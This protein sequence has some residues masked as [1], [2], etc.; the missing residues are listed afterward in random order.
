M[1]RQKMK[2]I[3]MAALLLCGTG[4]GTGTVRADPAVV[5]TDSLNVRSKPDAESTIIAGLSRGDKVTALDERFGWVK[6]Q[7]GETAGWVAGQY[8]LRNAGAGT[9]AKTASAAAP[10]A[11]TIP[12]R[13]RLT[14]DRVNLRA[15][16]G[17]DAKILDMAYIGDEFPLLEEK[18]NWVHVRLDNGNTAWIAGWLVSRTDEGTSAAANVS[19][20]KDTNGTSLSGDQTFST[21]SVLKGKRIVLDPG[22]GGKDGGAVGVKSGIPEKNL[23]LETAQ[24]VANALQA[25]GAKVSL[26][27]DGDEYI[28]LEERVD[29]ARKFGADLFIS[30]HYN[31]ALKSSSHGIFSFYYSG[32]QDMDL[33]RSLQKELV[34][35]TGL[36][37]MGSQYGDFH[38]LRENPFPAVL[39]EL[40]FLSNPGEESVVTAGGYRD[41]IAKAVVSGV[42]AYFD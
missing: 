25:A 13:I 8:L 4:L 32:K 36:K 5:G 26:T 29:A 3:A 31:S 12:S 40:G 1:V 6:V 21:S 33:A 30:L 18:D 19:A 28:S 11:K 41:R 24:A 15:A 42:K 39:L 22:H 2:T 7:F 37:D 10:G 14:A 9:S 27:R 16:P 38:V 34:K 20:G 35:A 17:T 23:T